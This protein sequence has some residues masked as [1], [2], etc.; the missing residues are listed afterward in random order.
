[1]NHAINA[2]APALEASAQPQ[3][4]DVAFLPL[5]LALMTLVITIS[6][7]AIG[8]RIYESPSSHAMLAIVTG[9][10]GGGLIAYAR[11]FLRLPW[12]SGPLVYLMLLWMFHF[13]YTF[14]AVLVPSM[15]TNLLDEEVEW[16]SYESTRLSMIL[17]ELGAA[18]FVASLGL[19]ARR[20]TLEA[21][22][23]KSPA[24]IGLYMI[25]WLIMVGAIALAMWVL[26]QYG[27]VAVFSMTYL[28]YRATVLNGSMMSSAM[29]LS[30]LGC[31]MAVCGGGGRRWVMPVTVWSAAIGVPTLLIGGRAPAMITG[32]TFLVVLTKLGVRFRRSFMIATIAVATVM[33]PSVYVIREVGFANRNAVNWTDVTPLDT[34]MELGSSLQATRAYVDWIERGDP[35]L[36][37]A[38]YWAPVDRQILSRVIPGREA[39]AYQQDERIPIRLMDERE[40]AIGGSAT[41]EAFYN[42]GALGPVLYFGSL[43]ILFGWLQRTPA[44]P[45]SAAVMGVILLVLCFNIRSDWLAVPAQIGQGLLLVAC[46]YLV[47][48]FA[49]PSLFNTSTKQSHEPPA[50]SGG[51]FA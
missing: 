30:Q 17:G 34:L 5:H 42:F 41:G 12:L 16:L 27:G 33:I 3:R 20:P 48:L 18:G 29:E 46:C 15:L 45:Y 7:A 50:L 40:G 25:G 10:A 6:L 28:E 8:T 31:L 19:F 38:S 26:V 51:R 37:G 44:S 24:Q 47:D 39:I 11:Y 32:L 1:M 22:T 23:A 9:L 43:G 21:P 13:G 2:L 49:V 14:T 4:K 36:L 35:F